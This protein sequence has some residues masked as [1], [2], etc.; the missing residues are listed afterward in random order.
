MTLDPPPALVRRLGLYTAVAVV[1]GSMIGSGIFKKPA[2]MADILHSPGL[3]LA[4]WVLAGVITC[5]GALSNAEVAGMF[6]EAGGQYVFFR[7]IYNDFAAYLYGWAIF[8]V[9]QTGSIA[10][11]AYV[12]A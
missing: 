9:I 2:V 6:P 12:F 8:A 5:F 3:L 10:S 7:R 11:I 4:T 1:V